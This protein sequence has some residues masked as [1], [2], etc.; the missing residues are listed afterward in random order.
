[1]AVGLV[2]AVAFQISRILEAVFDE[3]EYR[4]A[5]HASAR[6]AKQRKRTERRAR[7]LRPRPYQFQNA[8]QLSVR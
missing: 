4:S 3:I 1:M 2:D 7:K 6:M 5:K 8:Q